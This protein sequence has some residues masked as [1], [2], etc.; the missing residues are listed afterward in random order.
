MN[1]TQTADV[2]AEPSASG[3]L[4]ASG[5]AAYCWTL[6]GDQL[7]WSPN[8]AGVLEAATAGLCS[9]KQFAALIDPSCGASRYDAV[10][11]AGG[12]DA[13]QGV[14]FQ[15]EYLFRPDGRGSARGLWLEDAGR[16]FAGP[17]GRPARVLGTVRRIDE[18]RRE[19]QSLSFLSLYDPLTGM[20]NRLGLVNALRHA[21]TGAAGEASPCAL[22]VAAISNL[23]VVNEA[24]GFQTANEVMA[25]AGRRLARVTRGGDVI[26]RY[27]GSKF[28]LILHCCREEDIGAAAERFL[29]SL[30]ESVLDTEAGPLWALLSIGAVVLPRHA[31]D[32]EAA[33]TLAEEALA[34]ARKQP[35]DGFA[36]YEPSEERLSERVSNARYASVVVR[37]LKERHLHLAFQP[38]IDAAT[39]QPV[40]HEA[41]LRLTDHAGEPLPAGRVVQ[42][43]E[44]LGLV[45]LID[46]AVVLLAAQTLKSHPHVRISINISGTTATDPRWYPEITALLARNRD[47]ADRLIVEITETVALGDLAHTTRFVEQLRGLGVSVAIDDF[48]AG[49]TSFRNL[50][51]IPVDMLKIDGSFCR[52]LEADA[53]NRYFVQALIRLAKAFG[54]KT[55]AEWVETETDAELLQSWGIDLMQGKLFG[56]AVTLPGAEDLASPAE[57]EDTLALLEKNIEQEIERLRQAVEL[58]DGA[59]RVPRR[60]AV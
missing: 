18:R 26:A 51:A 28:G 15:I 38:V 12:T 31:T 32:P 20:M 5:L 53:D 39:R 54:L 29:A 35:F 52:N 22:L 43:A 24:Y 45:R 56:E 4:Q 47:V 57:A 23:A 27:S 17:D 46:Q 58:L 1:T 48:G 40:F 7:S 9:G 36:I 42:V 49:Y 60:S 37:C 11:M 41:L 34:L 50:R 14:P 8:A 13:G 2:P 55:V 30:R 19:Q 6:A 16:W 44:K 10:M 21:I 25:E 59:F 3:A 33:I